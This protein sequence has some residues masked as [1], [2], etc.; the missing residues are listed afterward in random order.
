MKAKTFNLLRFI[1]LNHNEKNENNINPPK[2][3]KNLL[4][5][6]K[7]KQINYNEKEN[8]QNIDNINTNLNFNKDIFDNIKYKKNK[9]ILLHQNFNEN[10]TNERIKSF[11]NL[12]ESL[13]YY[14][15][16]IENKVDKSFFT[17][18]K[19]FDLYLSE[20]SNGK[21]ISYERLA[22]ICFLISYKITGD[23]NHLNKVFKQ[24]PFDNKRIKKCY[25]FHLL[26]FCLF[27]FE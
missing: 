14:E 7:K 9:K 23:S 13:K 22:K 26:H 6:S 5:E 2:L 18:V 25:G 24:L 11:E 4:K 27:N 8:N 20:N 17:A 15:E 1:P 19:I 16:K 12:L 10:K 21:K 3:H